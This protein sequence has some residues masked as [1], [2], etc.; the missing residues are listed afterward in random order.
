M[1]NQKRKKLILWCSIGLALIAVAVV[2]TLLILHKHSGQ[3]EGTDTTTTDS[4]QQELPDENYNHTFGVSTNR[5]YIL[6]LDND[7]ALIIIQHIE[8]NVAN[9]LYYPWIEGSDCIS[10]Q[11]LQITIEKHQSILIID[12]KTLTIKEE[13]DKIPNMMNGKQHSFLDE[14]EQRHHFSLTPYAAPPYSEIVDNRFSNKRVYKVKVT[15]DVEYATADG[16]WTSV[17]GYQDDSYLKLLREKIKESKQ[18]RELSLTMDIYEPIGDQNQRQDSLLMMESGRP[19]IVLLHGGAFYVGDKG[20]EHI[21]GWSDYFA[22]Q[23]YICAAVNYRLGFRPLKREIEQA[24]YDAIDDVKKAL[25]YLI[26]HQQEYHIDTNR[27]FLA[28]T[29]AGSITALMTAFGKDNDF[30]ITAVANMWGAINNLKI[31]KNS[32]TDIISFHGTADQ[33]VPYDQ[34]I[35]FQDINKTIGKRMFS[36]LY[37]SA[38]IDRQA[39]ALGYRSELHTFEGGS[40]GL[41]EN[42]DHSIN[43]ENYNYIQEHIASFFY[44]EMVPQEIKIEQDRNDPRHFYIDNKN[45]TQVLWS[46]PNG[47]IIRCSD[48]DVWVLWPEESPSRRIEVSGRYNNGIGFRRTLTL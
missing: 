3:A 12:N 38:S 45:I 40:H 32:H 18:R 17:V 16:Y 25:R 27:L 42:P 2:T 8:D 22:Q 33:L 13:G 47:F 37:G 5:Y 31:L 26:Q 24:G 6:A 48:T 29:S 4:L 10:P 20:M 36:T 39:K 14:E 43:Y 9:G 34:G 46:V 11:P 21:A 7:T 44:R 1:D 35:P 19:L 30:H 28:G 15:K 41:H 23:G